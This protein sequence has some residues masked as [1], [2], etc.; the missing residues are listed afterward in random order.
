MAMRL[1]PTARDFLLVY[2][3]IICV[4]LSS[5]FFYFPTVF[6]ESDEWL[7]IEDDHF[8]VKYQSGYV[9]DANK[10]LNYSAYARDVVV[11]KFP[12][13]L[14]RK[15][16]VYVYKEPTKYNSYTIRWGH[17]SADYMKM[18]IYILAPSEAIRQSSYYDDLW[19]QANIIHEYVHVVVGQDIYTRTGK[20]MGN[21]LPPWFNEGIASYIPYYCTMSQIYQ[22]YSSNLERIGDSVR[23]GEGYLLCVTP[24]AY[25]GGPV[26]VK[27]M[28]ETYGQEAVINII[29]NDSPSFIHALTEELDITIREFEN[30]WLLWACKEFGVDYE[31]YSLTQ[32]APINIT[33]TELV[34]EMA[35]RDELISSL[36]ATIEIMSKEKSYL[37]IEYEALKANYDDLRADLD[38]LMDEYSNKISE[39]DELQS[40]YDSLYSDYQF[41]KSNLEELRNRYDE[42]ISYEKKAM[43]PEEFLYVS[44]ATTILFIATTIYYYLRSRAQS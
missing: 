20:Y 24:D 2:N 31:L 44:I 13:E 23:R 16:I 25:Y 35:K 10:V 37:D 14:S 34:S 21:Y 9:D 28:Y 29:E 42:L 39:Y 41:T 1:H 30:N 3:V 7:T 27:Y 26:L 12:Y 22:K 36:N 15:L 6:G 32:L 19:H 5:L 11:E 40:D 8:I 43:V 4:I 18:E 33:L 17:T 38:S